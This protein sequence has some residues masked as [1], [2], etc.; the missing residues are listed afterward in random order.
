MFF[1]KSI[2]SLIFYSYKV[3]EKVYTLLLKQQNTC[4]LN[5]TYIIIDF[6]SKNKSYFN[7]NQLNNLIIS[8]AIVVLK[9]IKT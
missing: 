4:Y 1:V 3:L 5:Y 9:K 7:N 2:F 6:A 8:N